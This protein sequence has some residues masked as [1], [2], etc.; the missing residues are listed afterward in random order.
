MSS[1]LVAHLFDGFRFRRGPWTI[2]FEHGVIQ[3]V[4]RNVNPDTPDAPRDTTVLPGLID[5]HVH[6]VLDGTRGC[7]EHFLASDASAQISLAKRNLRLAVH[8]GVTTLR[9]CGSPSHLVRWLKTASGYRGVL[10]TVLAAGPPI[11]TTL[12]HGHFFGGGGPPEK[13]SDAA[14]TGGGDFVKIMASGGGLTPGSNPLELQYS[15]LQMRDVVREVQ[16]GGR[17]VA[18][19]AHTEAAVEIAVDAGVNSIEHAT[20]LRRNGIGFRSELAA[21]IVD[22][23]VFV[24]PTL[25]GFEIA[26]R[27]A[28]PAAQTAV[29]ERDPKA[30]LEQR[31]HAVQTLIEHNV[32]IAAGTDAGA[33]LLPFD[34]LRSE[35]QS[36]AKVGL[37]SEGALGA[38]T[39]NAADCL[40]LP[41]RGRIQVGLRA[42]FI[43]VRASSP[44]EALDSIAL[45]SAVYVGGKRAV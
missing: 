26:V 17:Y 1:I 21:K 13:A 41:D 14:R 33:R 30:L 42:D 38:A 6:L 11:T 3:S 37:G 22:A 10:P 43:V 9:D 35:I 31:T 29:R 36:L 12:G 5:C 27:N 20:G 39:A 18:A 8:A 2:H 19:H 4:D 16:G 25:H 28:L 34:S 7:L 40:R 45:P 23:G 15:G 44:D 24:V 32:T